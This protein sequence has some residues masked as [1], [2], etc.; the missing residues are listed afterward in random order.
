MTRII[1]GLAPAALL[2]SFLAPRPAAA[3]P[4]STAENAAAFV[5]KKDQ[6]LAAKAAAPAPQAF[7]AEL[8]R[9]IGKPPH[10]VINIFNTWTHDTVV[11]DEGVLDSPL[12]PATI[13]QFLRCHFT[14]APTT[15]DERLFPVLLQAARRFQVRRIEI[16]SGFRHPKYNLTLRKKGRQVARESQHT[17]GHAIDFRLPGVSTDRLHQWARSLRLGGVGFYADSAFV[18]VD[19]G[20]IR[21]WTGK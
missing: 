14:N 12:G 11:V 5:S 9:R 20:R 10:P 18:H 8:D 13:N 16:V 17:E 2:W 15:M 1:A 6:R 3:N 7:R 4:G 21:Y 19:V